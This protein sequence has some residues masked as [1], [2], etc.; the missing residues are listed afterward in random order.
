[1]FSAAQPHALRQELSRRRDARRRA[2]RRPP[3]VRARPI[4]ATTR[5]VRR[6]AAPTRSTS[7]ATTRSSTN[8]TDLTLGVQD[9]AVCRTAPTSASSSR[10]IGSRPTRSPIRSRTAVRRSIDLFNPDPFVSYTPAYAKTG[11]TSNARCQLG[12]ALRVRHGASFNEQFQADLGIRWDRVKVDYDDGRRRRASWRTSAATDNATTGPR[13]PRLQAGGEGQHLR[14]VTARRS[15]PSFDGTLGLTLAATGVN[16]QALGPER[17]AQLRSRRRS[18]TSPTRSTSRRPSSIIEK[19]NAKTTDLAGDGAWLGDQRVNGVEF[20]VA[21]HHHC[22]GGAPSAACRSWTARCI[23]SGD[24][25][26]RGRG[27]ALR[28]EGDSLNLWTTYRLAD[29]S[30]RRRRRELQRAATSS[31]RPAASTSSAAARCRSRSTSPTR[32]RFRR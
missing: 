26:G 1:M 5:P 18:G 10:T 15:R 24:A 19:T 28:A 9:R 30:D 14:R 17:S 11:A 21:G 3:P 20:T 23:K 6:C 22:R 27:A 16:G 31:T 13:R 7:T 25:V 4:R 29:A 12:G 8:Q 32:R 2:R